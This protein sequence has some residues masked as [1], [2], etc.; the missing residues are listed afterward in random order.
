MM[1]REGGNFMKHIFLVNPAAGKKGNAESII[2]PQIEAYCDKAGI[3]YEIYVTKCQGDAQQHCNELA[4]TGESYRFYACG[5]DGTI[6]EVVNGIFGYPNCEFAAIPLGSGNDFIRLFGTKEEFCN[7]EAQ[8]TGIPVDLDV[9]KCGDKIAVNQCSMGM[10][11]EVC[12]KQA[13]FKKL[14]LINGEMAYGL[15]AV[16]ALFKHLGHR[17]TIKIDD[18]EPYTDDVLFCVSAN[19]RWYGGGYQAAPNAWPDDGKLDFVVIKNATSRIRLFP[20]LQIYKKGQHLDL[21]ITKYVNGKRL[22][23]HSEIPAAVNIDGECEF[24]T[25]CVF[26]LVPKGIRFVVPQF[27]SFHEGRAERE[28]NRA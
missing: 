9:I 28:A 19:S 3:D 14:P 5:G 26:E 7:V 25:D 1:E 8:V 24:V 6:Y 11:A 18:N 12:A 16:R 22:E 21:P 2:R 23:V 20:L 4:K 13:D 10:D 17:F 27:S 15:A